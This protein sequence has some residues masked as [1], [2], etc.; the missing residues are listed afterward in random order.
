[1]IKLVVGL[2]NPGSRY[3]FTR[4]NVGFMVVDLLARRWEVEL[5]DRGC[6]SLYG[7]SP[8]G[9]Y[10]VKPQTYVNSS[11][12]AIRAWVNRGFSPRE[13]L[14]VHDDIDLPFGVV[15]L[16]F[17]GG[18]G[19]HK[20]LRSIMEEIGTGDFAR[21]RIGVGRPPGREHDH[22]AIVDFLL[23]PFSSQR[24]DLMA[25]LRLAADAVETVLRKGLDS[26]MNLVNRKK[27]ELGG[28]DSESEL[29]E[30]EGTGDMKKSLKEG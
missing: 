23:S 12:K 9:V 13:M 22:E 30:G 14:V 25:T 1:M 17:G 5:E 10:L 20:G 26:A 28:G 27:G 21:L 24:E 11:G 6:Q 8:D 15:R 29:R 19:G 16:K 3:L 4:H 7:V 18:S 2:G